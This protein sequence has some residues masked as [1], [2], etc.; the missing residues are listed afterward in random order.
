[1]SNTPGTTGM[2]LTNAK[3]RG[4]KAK[5]WEPGMMMAEKRCCKME[6]RRAGNGGSSA[7]TA[8]RET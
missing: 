4:V 2:R 6:R 3:V 8:C 7:A 5:T 1:M